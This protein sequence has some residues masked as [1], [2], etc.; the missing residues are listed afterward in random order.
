MTQRRGRPAQDE[1]KHL[2]SLAGLTCNPSIEDDHGWDFLVEIPL[3]VASGTPVD[4]W[5]GVMPVFVQVK[6]TGREFRRTEM[7]VSNARQLATKVEPCFL[8][9]FH[10]RKDG[11]QI[12]ARLFGERDIERTLR[13]ARKLSAEGKRDHRAKITFGFRDDEEHTASLVEWLVKCVAGL[14]QDYAAEKIRLIKMV[15]YGKRN[16]MARLTMAGSRGLADFVDL[17]L[18]VK[19]HVEV[20]GFTISDLRFGIEAPHPIAEEGPATFRLHPEQEIECVVTLKSG[21]DA[22]S[23]ESTARTAAVPGSPPQETKL[24]FHNDL[25]MLLVAMDRI[26][27]TVRDIWSTWLRMEELE[28]LTT[29]LSWHDQS[30]RIRVTGNDVPGLDLSVEIGENPAR[31]N[32]T[33]PAAVRT[34]RSTADRCATTDIALSMNDLRASYRGLSLYNAVLTDATMELRTGSGQLSFDHAALHN[35]LGFVDVEVGE[36]TFLTVFD[37]PIQ[38]RS[39]DQKS[40]S[41][42]LGRRTSR[43]CV[44][45]KGRE[46]VRSQGRSLYERCVG[47]YGDDWL[48]VDSLNELIESGRQRI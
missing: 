31:L 43:E 45:G 13:R 41:I 19:D 30:M 21:D 34:L 10:E 28:K 46:A 26:E 8:V 38:T 20:S 37:A 25:F 11:T 24:A 29:I 32:R 16:F 47:I 27:L 48:G 9:L 35:L 42:D 2:C 36:Y 1:F 22:V 3:P 7:K 44:V 15:G 33:I 12:Y 40:V 17:Q 6:S 39:D 14:G 18:G 23:F 4:K 5:P